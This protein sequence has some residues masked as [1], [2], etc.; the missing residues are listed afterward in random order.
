MDHLYVACELGAEHGRV[1]LGTLRQGRL[2]LS[3]IHRFPNRPLEDKTARS[4]DIPYVYAEILKGLREIGTYEES[5]HSVSCHSWGGDYMLFDADGSL[6]LPVDRHSDSKHAAGLQEI[7]TQVP[8]ESIYDETGVAL[9]PENTLFQLVNEK[10][11]RLNNASQLLPIADA[12]NYLLSGVAC[13]ELSAAGTT[14][15]FNPLTQSWSQRL[16][17]AARLPEK[18]FPAI[19]PAG[20]PLAVLHPSIA[21]EVKMEDAQV[22]ATCSH[23][24]AA[25]LAGLPIDP[26]ESWAFMR[27]GSR[28]LMGTELGEPF[29]SDATRESYFSNQIGQAGAVGFHKQIMGLWVLEECERFW[30]AQDREIDRTML[31]HFAGESTAFESWVDL[32]DPR[33]L[34]PGDMPLKIQA[35]CRETNQPVPRKPGPIARCI[36]ESLALLHRD[37]LREIE[38]FS[39]RKISRL[40]VFDGPEI[41]LLHHFTAN[42]LQIPLVLV[43][44]GSAA[45]GNIM[46]QAL[47]QGHV[48]SVAEAREV[49]RNSTK[50][51]TISPHSKIW[52]EACAR[53]S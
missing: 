38:F 47:A 8:W 51:K 33:F 52:A 11:R 3:E 9:G 53:L 12:F 15:L 49:L 26:E 4:W 44:P 18:L 1:V 32:N 36:L 31:I 37:T 21:G 41:G 5:I 35:Y 43:P 23:E 10:S 28:T 42:A 6:N 24:A 20:T 25:A 17:T 16:L 13:V 27:P 2:L 46:V 29:I 19:V 22:F 39:G 48:K 14:Q 7:L 45:A 30:K 40:Y 34:T 50:T